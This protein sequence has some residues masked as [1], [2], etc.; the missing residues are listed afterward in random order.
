MLDE[1]PAL[2][3]DTTPPPVPD[4]WRAVRHGAVKD[5]RP[6]WDVFPVMDITAGGWLIPHYSQVDRWVPC[7]RVSREAYYR[8]LQSRADILRAHRVTDIVHDEDDW[9]AY[10]DDDV[11][12]RPVTADQAVAEL[13]TNRDARP[14]AGTTPKENR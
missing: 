12:G 2:P 11:W 4:S 5:G 6:I 9:A 13:L 1:I 10:C 14:I 8:D 3:H 7:R